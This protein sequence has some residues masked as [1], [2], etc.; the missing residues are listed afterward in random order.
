MIRASNAFA[1]PTLTPLQTMQKY[2]LPLMLITVID[3]M[4]VLLAYKVAAS[5][6]AGW[7]H[8]K[9]VG[10]QFHLYPPVEVQ[11]RD[12]SFMVKN[13]HDHFLNMLKEQFDIEE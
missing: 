6:V 12:L 3:I 2:T 5:D 1:H 9:T 10:E 4:G 13:M 7:P 11:A 8:R